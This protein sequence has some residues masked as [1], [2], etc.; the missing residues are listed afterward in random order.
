[1]QRWLDVGRVPGRRLAVRFVVD[2]AYVP[3]D[4]D[5]DP[6]DPDERQLGLFVRSARLA[7]TP[8]LP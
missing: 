8:D 4:E 1:M 2:S 6:D 3:D 7:A 5:P